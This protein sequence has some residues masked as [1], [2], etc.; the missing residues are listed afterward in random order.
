MWIMLIGLV[1]IIIFSLLSSLIDTGFFNRKLKVI[2][3]SYDDKK[4]VFKYPEV[5]ISIQDP[6]IS[7]IYNN[8]KICIYDNT[9]TTELNET[10]REVLSLVDNKYFDVIEAIKLLREGYKI[11]NKN[12]PGFSIQY[13]P[14]IDECKV[15]E[16]IKFMTALKLNPSWFIDSASFFKF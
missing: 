4:E 8:N 3:K 11:G 6:N 12:I 10:N 14:D 9:K 15:E 13:D 1:V 2:I 16:L 7:F 5:L